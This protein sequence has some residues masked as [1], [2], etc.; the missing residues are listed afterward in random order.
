[1][2]CKVE[3][4]RID[5]GLKLSLFR[6]ALSLAVSLFMLPQQLVG[7]GSTVSQS[8]GAFCSSMAIVYDCAHYS[9]MMLGPARP[10]MEGELV[11]L[12]GMFGGAEESALLRLILQARS[13]T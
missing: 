11:Y 7:T 4:L 12:K 1:M 3:A 6:R 9:D 10:E 2:G 8:L 13:C 5:G